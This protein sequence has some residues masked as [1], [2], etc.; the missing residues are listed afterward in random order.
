MK[1]L[2][3]LL[4]C[5]VCLPTLAFSDTDQQRM[6]GHGLALPATFSGTLPCAD[7]PGIEYH[8]DIWDGQQGYALRR[9]YLERDLVID[10]VGRWHVD[11]ARNAL[12]LE[13]TG[14]ARSEWQIT[15]NQEI[16]LLDQEG[17]P[18]ESDLP[19][20]LVSGPLAPTD[21]RLTVTGLMTYFADAALFTECLTGQRFPIAMEEDYL[22]LERAYLAAEIVPG[23]PLLAHL[24]AEI[25]MR[26][27]M[28]GADRMT[29]T[30]T[31]FHHITPDAG[32]PD[33]RMP[34]EFE[35]TYW[36]LTHLQGVEQDQ[37][38]ERQE[39]YLLILEEG[40]RFGGTIGCNRL[41]G[42]VTREGA[43]VE[44]GPTASTMMACPDDLAEKEAAFANA[45]SMTRGLDLMDQ[46]LRLLDETGVELARFNALY[47]RY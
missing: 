47:T 44:F 24:D 6:G 39:P 35:N 2:S 9:S 22:A 7:C 10:E 42:Q 34:A 19:Y 28:E 45:L 16:R 43:S 1:H 14:N 3:W 13:G 5:S 27:Q 32:C 21:L 33:H 30:V 25:S 46:S 8:L 31:Q 18:I 12:I 23:A 29:V 4:V 17:Q 40:T 41:M 11:P 37:S 38:N 20:T 36:G 26:P 15:P